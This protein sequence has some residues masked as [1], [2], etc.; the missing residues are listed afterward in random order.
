M[1]SA[2][3]PFQGL[4]VNKKLKEV[5]FETFDKKLRDFI[6]DGLKE[7]NLLSEDELKALDFIRKLEVIYPN[8]RFTS[9]NPPAG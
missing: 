6:T 9:I 7:L 8:Q 4:N 3:L 5:C 2:K 1:V